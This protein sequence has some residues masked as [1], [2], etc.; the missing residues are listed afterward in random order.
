MTIDELISELKSVRQKLGGGAEVVMQSTF[1]PD[2]YSRNDSD[3][4]SGLFADVFPSTVETV[5][6]EENGIFNKHVRLYWQ[7]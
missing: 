6:I 3:N 7:L 2:G 1:L 4:K 5:R